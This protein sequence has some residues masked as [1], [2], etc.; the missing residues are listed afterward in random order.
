M[1]HRAVA[2]TQVLLLWTLE[3]GICVVAPMLPDWLRV[4]LTHRMLA[5]LDF[6]ARL[7]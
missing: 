5:V 6:D 3:G 4:L 1:G 2:C 7:R